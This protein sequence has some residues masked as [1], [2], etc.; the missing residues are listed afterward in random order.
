MGVL[1]GLYSQ[2]IWH[3][4]VRL[5]V[6]APLPRTVFFIAKTADIPGK[7][8]WRCPRTWN[9]QKN[10]TNWS[11]TA[12]LSSFSRMKSTSWQIVYSNP[13]VV[14]QKGEAESKILPWQKIYLAGSS[15]LEQVIFLSQNQTGSTVRPQSGASASSSPDTKFRRTNIYILSWIM[16]PG[17]KWANAL[18][19]I[20]GN[21]QILGGPLL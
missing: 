3:S 10:W 8:G 20:A 14:S 4:H 15:C 7:R 5:A 16:R 21:I 18:S 11:R 19:I 9:V 12:M 13:P 6:P 1:I 2:G 17:I